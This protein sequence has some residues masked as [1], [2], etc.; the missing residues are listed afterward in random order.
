M[1]E[2]RGFYMKRKFWFFAQF[3]PLK[4]KDLFLESVYQHNYLE[5]LKDW[6]LSKHIRTIAY[7]KYYFQQDEATKIRLILFRIGR[8]QNSTINL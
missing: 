6:Y 4:C 7:K 8:D 1:A 5:M 3:S 2:L